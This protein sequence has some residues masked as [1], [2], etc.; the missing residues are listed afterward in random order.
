MRFFEVVVVSY[1]FFSDRIP[2]VLD[3][4]MI[5]D[6]DNANL[7][8]SFLHHGFRSSEIIYRIDITSAIRKI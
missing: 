3:W 1:S 6:E 5:S 8:N 4:S 7:V 2:A